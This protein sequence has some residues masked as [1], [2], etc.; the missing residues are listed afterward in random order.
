MA[1]DSV[2]S[3]KELISNSLDSDLIITSGGVS[4]GEADFTKEAFSQMGIKTIFD[5]IVIKPGK[6]T[7][8]GK[9]NNKTILI[10]QEIH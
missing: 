2:E 10:Y 8:V 5:G 4:V 1:K 7:V 9:I 6:P 3:L